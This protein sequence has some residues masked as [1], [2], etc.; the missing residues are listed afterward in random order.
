MSEA[1]EPFLPYG[2]QRIS[3]ADIEAVAEALGEPM[4]TQ[5]PR[6]AELERAIC[7][8]TGAAHAVAVSSGTAALHAA[9]AAAGIGAGDV[10][11]VPAITFAASANCIRYVGAEVR[12]L[13]IDPATLNLDLD[14]A[15]RIA[16]ADER[17]KAVVPVSFAG[18]PVDLEPLRAGGL[19]L[20]E[21]GAHALGSRRGG[22]MVGGPGGAE[23]T[24]FSLHP[25]KAITSGEGGVVTTEDAPLAERARR[26]REHGMERSPATSDGPWFYD[27][28]QTG[29]NY[30]ITDFQSAL[31][32]SQLA[33]LTEW[34]GARN[35]IA[36]AY[37]ELLASEERLLLPPEAPAGSIHAYHLFT[38]Q[39]KAGAE[40]RLRA[41]EGMRAGGIGVQVHYIPIYRF[42]AYAGFDRR[43][44]PN[45]ETYY[46]GALSLPIFPGMEPEDVSRV[47]GTLQGLLD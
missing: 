42:S 41:F 43:D 29:F 31:A 10:A 33:N 34:I 15:V 19:K 17:V 14:Q 30:R 39:I 40:A 13:D 22:E 18:L 24:C 6:V 7:E 4:I 8:F 27:V 26:F 23:A 1:S 21:D 11:L 25:V 28:S 37:R 36:T 46:A 38:V 35:E 44:F 5:G 12:L 45:A 47:V 32:T 2:R 3:E 20:I 9:A 16:A